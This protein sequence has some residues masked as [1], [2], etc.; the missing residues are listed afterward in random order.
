MKWPSPSALVNTLPDYEAVDAFPG[1][2]IAT[3]GPN[4]GHILDKR[5]K[6]TMPSFGNLAGKGAGELRGILR[7]AIR[8]QREAMGE[9][10][11]RDGGEFGEIRKELDRLEKWC[12]KMNVEKVEKEA[13]KVCKA[14]KIEF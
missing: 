12:D 4:V 13:A 1:V 9:S 6:G 14:N 10:K 11:S 5:D 3:S 8:G 7:E 2:Y